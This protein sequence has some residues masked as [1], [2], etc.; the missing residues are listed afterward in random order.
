MPSAKQLWSQIL[1]FSIAGSFGLILYYLTLYALTDLVGV[2]YLLSAII[3]SIVNYSSNFLL[4][5]FW[6]FKNK[7]LQGVHRQIGKYLALS[8]SLVIS[9]LGLLYILVEYF[10]LWYLG[11]QAILT[12]IGG[13]I[14]FLIIRLI[15]RD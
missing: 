9:N 5:K 8:L 13:M 3:A 10:Q 15:F 11:A 7:N 6:T 14:S 12:I 2:W 1:R 4:H